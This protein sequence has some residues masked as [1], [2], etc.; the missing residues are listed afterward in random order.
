MVKNKAYDLSSYSFSSQEAVLIDANIWMYLFPP[1]SDSNLK[2]AKSY[3][4]AFS[5]LIKAGAKP[6]LDPLILSEYLNRYCR[7]EWYACYDKQYPYIQLVQ[8]N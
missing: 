1:P 5:E 6:I 4:K 3:S 2:F 7:I 8:T